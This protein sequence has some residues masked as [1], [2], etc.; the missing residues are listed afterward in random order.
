MTPGQD[1][2]CQHLPASA[3]N[4]YTQWTCPV[5]Y[6][7]SHM[8]VSY[9]R[10]KFDYKHTM[11]VTTTRTTNTLVS[12]LELWTHSCQLPQLGLLAHYMSYHKF[13]Y[14]HTMWVLGLQTHPCEWPQLWLQDTSMSFELPQ[15]QLWLLT[16]PWW[17]PDRPKA[18]VGCM[19]EQMN[20]RRRV[21]PHLIL[22]CVLIMSVVNICLLLDLCHVSQYCSAAPTL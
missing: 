7:N 11:W 20:G 13:D 5:N 22:Q 6:L 15:G 10:G 17:H 2:V 9:H 8:H 12:E 16:H 21:L 18:V 19:G 1:V 14:M 3:G 4:I